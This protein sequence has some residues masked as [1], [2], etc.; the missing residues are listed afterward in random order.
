MGAWMVARPVSRQMSW[1]ETWFKTLCDRIYI[2]LCVQMNV[3]IRFPPPLPHSPAPLLLLP[4]PHRTQT[5]DRLLAEV[6]FSIFWRFK[7]PTSVVVQSTSKC[8]I[9]ATKMPGRGFTRPTVQMA[10]SSPPYS[11]GISFLG[12]HS[13]TLGYVML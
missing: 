8:W 6:E 7:I 1:Q 13:L 2:Q 9:A 4:Y 10:W 3:C 5:L 11:R 12:H